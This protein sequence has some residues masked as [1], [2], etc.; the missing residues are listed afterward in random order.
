MQ[1]NETLCDKLAEAREAAA[2]QQAAADSLRTQLTD[3]EAAA[4]AAGEIWDP[5]G[6]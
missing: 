5:F 3:I 1:A 4:A 6:L 2:G